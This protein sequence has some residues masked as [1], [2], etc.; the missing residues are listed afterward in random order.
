MNIWFTLLYQ[1][2]VNLLILFYNLLGHNIG[3]AIIGLT[4]GIRTAL[5][6]LISPS[7]N[8]SL[9]MKEMAP[10]L[11]KIKAKF[12]NNKQGLAQAQMELYKKHGIN[13]AAGCLP[14]IVQIVILIALFQAFNQV[15]SVDQNVTQKLNEI[16]YPFFRFGQNELINIRFLY[17]DLT[18]PDL[19]NL[20]FKLTFF[21]K[22]FSSLPGIFL[23]GAAVSQF[24]SSKL[25]MPQV[26]KEKQLAK[27][28]PQAQDDLAV[29]MQSQMLYLMPLMTIV[30]GFRFPSGLVL[31]WL[32]F[33]LFMLIQQLIVNKNKKV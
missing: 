28:T 10:E 32:T 13:P 33:S 3:L 18:K 19:I 26:K 11:D 25:M 30:L 21:G 1:P 7:M 9:K 15:L 4:I 20:P 5:I 29:A 6:P 22:S 16:V 12:K 2:L 8:A 14:Q 27:N 23:I 17:L 24:I 31:Y